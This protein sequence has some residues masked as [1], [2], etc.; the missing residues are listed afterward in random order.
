MR[1]YLV[2]TGFLIGISIS[3]ILVG[4]EIILAYENS[5]HLDLE[6]KLI[7]LK[8]AEVERAK[9]AEETKTINLGFQNTK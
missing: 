3:V 1:N 9:K 2:L 7:A 8:L 4:Q 5:I 6:A